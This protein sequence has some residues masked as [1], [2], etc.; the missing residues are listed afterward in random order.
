[1]TAEKEKQ[2]AVVSLPVFCLKKSVQIREIRVILCAKEILVI[3][4]IL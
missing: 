3:P 2:A 4:K 1:M